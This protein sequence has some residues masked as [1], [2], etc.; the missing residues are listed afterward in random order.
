MAV[1]DGTTWDETTPTDAT[2]AINIDDYNRD[3][4]VGVR[5]RMAL[6]HEWPDSQS[7]TS[8]AGKHKY[9]TLQMQST[10]PTIA[11][12]QVGA[13]YQKTVA[14]TGDALFFLSKATKEVNISNRVYFWYLAE[15]AETGSNV[16]STMYLIS[17][18]D[19]KNCRAYCSTTASGGTG[20]QIDVL[21]NGNSIWTATSAQLLLAP[22]S[23]STSVVAANIVTKAVTAG[24]VFTIDVDKV[25]TGTAGGGITVM[26][27]VG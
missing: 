14:T 11:G 20:I 6:E 27:E 3:V 4:R 7:A 8:E 9:L 10:A 18:G 16:S 12:T 19:I 17:D 5:S 2:V 23:T 26:V 15:E 22:G 1:G 25:G 21:Y 24:G 13:V